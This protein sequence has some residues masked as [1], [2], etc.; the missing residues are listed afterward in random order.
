MTRKKSFPNQYRIK[1]H[2]EPIPKGSSFIQISK[3]NFAKAYQQMSRA[4]GALALY[5]WLVGN[6]N[7][8]AFE[9][10]P[11]AVFNQLGMAISTTHGA[12]NRLREEGYL[13][14]RE[15]STTFDFYEVAQQSGANQNAERESKDEESDF[16]S[17]ELKAKPGEFSF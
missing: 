10:S 7:N 4:P 13:V 6:Q 12:V 3:E 17:P 8:Y 1:I 2:R 14:R 16:P 15:E 11:Q 5:V 9:F